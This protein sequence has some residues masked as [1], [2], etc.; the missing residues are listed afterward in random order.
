MGEQGALIH[1]LLDGDMEMT[2][3]IIK[4]LTNPFIC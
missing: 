4:L 3:G 1:W 2:A